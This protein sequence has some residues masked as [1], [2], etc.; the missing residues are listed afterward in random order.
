MSP[1]RRFNTTSRYTAFSIKSCAV[2]AKYENEKTP[3]T[4]QD[5]TE[6]FTNASVTSCSDRLGWN[7]YSVRDIRQDGENITVVTTNIPNSNQT[8]PAGTTDDR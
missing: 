5:Y 1:A 2:T 7:A 3:T 8:C 4:N 6:Q